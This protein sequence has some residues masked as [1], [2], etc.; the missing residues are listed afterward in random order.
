M[1]PGHP[2]PRLTAQQKRMRE[3]EESVYQTLRAYQ[4]GEYTAD[5]G[6]AAGQLDIAL[7]RV[8]DRVKDHAVT[9]FARKR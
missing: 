7:T 3:F 4:R 6:A 5:S 9:I 1:R 8:F 2:S